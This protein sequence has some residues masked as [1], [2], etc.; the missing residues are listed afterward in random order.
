MFI[1]KE[2]Y[3]ILGVLPNTD[4]TIIETAYRALIK[5]Y[6]LDGFTG[7]KEEA[8]RKIKEINEAYSVLSDPDKKKTYAESYGAAE[9]KD[10]FYF[11][12]KNKDQIPHYDPLKADWD[13]A[14][15]DHPDLIELEKKLSQISWRLGYSYRA[16]LIESG[17]FKKRARL[18]HDLEQA[19]LEIYFGPKPEIKGFAHDL[20]K[21]GNKPAARALNRSLKSFGGSTGSDKIISKIRFEY[22]IPGTEKEYFNILKDLGYKIVFKKEGLFKS[23]YI[24][25]V[26]FPDKKKIK[27]QTIK[28]LASF[29]KEKQLEE[30]KRLQEN[31]LTRKTENSYQ[32]KLKKIGY[33]LHSRKDGWIVTNAN[34]EK[35]RITT[36]E[37]LGSFLKEKLVDEV[38]RLQKIS[39]KQKLENSYEYK[40][41]QIG[42]TLHSSKDGWILTGT[43]K[44]KIKI[45][46]L[47]LI[48]N[49]VFSVKRK[50]LCESVLDKN[51]Y[52]LE[53]KR[54]KWVITNYIGNKKVFKN[55]DD[56]ERY[57]K[58][59]ENHV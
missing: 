59:I 26:T 24:W 25:E 42:Y 15:E 7:P 28:E 38:N 27:I 55:L 30:N 40:L 4:N 37:D 53:E 29:I 47:D 31:N 48:N 5:I 44:R 6:D 22:N 14:V 50:M 3:S 45:K 52:I 32:N 23:N 19:F 10:S 49:F 57:T 39:A 43:N 46:S 2:Y 20:L 11:K 51:G 33:R 58:A 9:Q 12:D 17:L 35:T 54:R 18:A 21:T 36:L 34:N 1:T 41:E 56:L 8:Q 16:Y 13:L